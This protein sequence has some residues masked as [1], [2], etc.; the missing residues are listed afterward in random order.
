MADTAAPRESA[1]MPTAAAESS[2]PTVPMIRRL[3]LAPPAIATGTTRVAVAHG[4]PLVRAGVRAL[5]E[6]EPGIAVVGEAATGEEALDLARRERPDVVVVDTALPG[7]DCVETTRRALAE[8]GI[9]VMVLTPSETDERVLAAMRAGASAVVLE[10]GGPGD[11]VRAVTH[12]ARG[13]R[14]GSRRFRRSRRVVPSR[15]ATTISSSNGGQSWSC[16][17]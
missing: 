8:P 9:A 13:L 11:L 3:T 6:C 7:L 10:D 14:P 12:V 16:V 4:R 5:L 2:E 1:G 17:I 15:P